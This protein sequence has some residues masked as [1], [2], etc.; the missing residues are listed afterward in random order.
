MVGMTESQLRTGLLWWRNTIYKE[1]FDKA[2]TI[3]ITISQDESIN[4]IQKREMQAIRKSGKKNKGAG[5]LLALHFIDTVVYA[6]DGSKMTRNDKKEFVHRTQAQIIRT[7]N[8]IFQEEKSPYIE[9]DGTKSQNEI[10]EIL[11]RKVVDTIL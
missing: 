3:H 2:T 5:T 7:Y 6:P 1:L 4:R 10:M 9:I 8:D 11:Q